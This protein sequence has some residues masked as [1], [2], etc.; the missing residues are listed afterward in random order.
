MNDTADF[1][2]APYSSICG[3]KYLD[4]N[5]DGDWD[6]GENGLKDIR[7]GC[8]AAIT[9]TTP[10]RCPPLPVVWDITASSA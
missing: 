6:C 1:G 5:A 9:R 7:V 4:S 2:N 8:V 10:L 3:R